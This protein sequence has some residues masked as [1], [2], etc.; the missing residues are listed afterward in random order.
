MSKPPPN[1]HHVRSLEEALA[2][3]AR[4]W[5]HGRPAPIFTVDPQRFASFAPYAHKS[6]TL[7]VQRLDGSTA[8]LRG[9]KLQ[10]QAAPPAPTEPPP[11][12]LC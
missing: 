4:E 12:S 7:H 1:R 5:S 3:Y 8:I 6:Y 2:A 11:H 10:F 9:V